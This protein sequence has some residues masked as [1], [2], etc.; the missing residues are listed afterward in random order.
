MLKKVNMY[1][2]YPTTKIRRRINEENV[3]ML[4][5]GKINKEE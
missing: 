5:M 3:R 2:E 1:L 4:E